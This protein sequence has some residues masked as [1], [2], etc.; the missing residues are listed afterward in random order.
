MHSEGVMCEII[1][2]LS[3]AFPALPFQFIVSQCNDALFPALFLAAIISKNEK[4]FNLRMNF[5]TGEKLLYMTI[6]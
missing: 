3:K 6:L 1:R 5:E 4:K 2:N